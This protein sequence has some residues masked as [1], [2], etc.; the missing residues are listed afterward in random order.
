[1]YYI[2]AC[3]TSRIICAEGMNDTSNHM[4]CRGEVITSPSNSNE[5]FSPG[6]VQTGKKKCLLKIQ[7]DEIIQSEHQ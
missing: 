6:D 7:Y 5:Q 2:S 3:N 4:S 1:M